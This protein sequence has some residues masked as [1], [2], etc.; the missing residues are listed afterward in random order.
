MYQL[1]PKRTN[2]SLVGRA[3][4]VFSQSVLMVV[5]R[6]GL[7]DIDYEFVWGVVKI[8]RDRDKGEW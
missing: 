2:G 7:V 6:G 4:T 5:S 3:C 1:W 8:V